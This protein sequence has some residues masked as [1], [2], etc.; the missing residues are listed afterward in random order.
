MGGP[1]RLEVGTGETEQGLADDGRW[2]RS[3]F[4]TTVTSSKRRFDST[5]GSEI[6]PLRSG[7]EVTN[8]K[9]YF[10]ASEGDEWA[11]REKKKQ[12]A[13]FKILA[14]EGGEGAR[15]DNK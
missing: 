14:R 11:R 8:Q 2:D 1:Q 5:T 4:E 10:I 12:V 7:G 9:A 3:R 6:V 13:N 15:Q